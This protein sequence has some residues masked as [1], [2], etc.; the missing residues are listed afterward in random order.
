MDKLKVIQYMIDSGI[1]AVIRSDSKDDAIK[2]VEAVKKG[3]INIVEITMTIPNAIDVI[4]ELNE[5]YKKDDTMLIGAGTVLDPE[6]ARTCILAGATFIVSPSLN[7]DTIKLCNRY[8]VPIIPGVI[9]PTEVQEAL[10]MGIDILKIFPSNIADSSI[11]KAL[12]APFPQAMFMPSGGVKL[13]N[14]NEWIE[15]GVSMLSTGSD[16]TKSAKIGDY[17]KVTE[18]AKTYVRHYKQLRGNLNE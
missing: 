4:K 2:T 18:T 3:G 16:L 13:E 11:V 1:V 17:D 12:K 8:R 14:L 10:E 9:T 15:A 7:K 5:I 6:T